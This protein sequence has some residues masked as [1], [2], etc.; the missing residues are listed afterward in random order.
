[1]TE[2]VHSYLEVAHFPV[3]IDR[4]WS[5]D[6]LLMAAQKSVRRNTGWPVGIVMT[7]PEYSPKPVSEGIRAIVPSAL[8]DRFDFWSL[9]R[10]GRFYFLRTLEEDSD[11]RIAPGTSLYFDTRIWRIAEALL[12]CANLYRA[13][14]LSLETE[15]RIQI[16]HCG[17]RGRRLTSSDSMRAFTMVGRVCHEDQS[18]WAKTVPLGTIEPNI[19][20]LVR[21]IGGELFILFEFWK[22]TPEVWKG[23]VEDYLSSR[24]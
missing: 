5:Q 18:Q 4:K 7:N 22:P 16:T 24:V 21:E 6:E 23:V 2:Q 8:N 11:D 14:G 3:G 12:H 9:D 13:L 1:M 19:E 17:L 10:S 20:A 15:I